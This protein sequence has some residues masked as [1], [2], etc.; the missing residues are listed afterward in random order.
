MNKVFK[1]KAQG[2]YPPITQSP[3]ITIQHER[4]LRELI[5]QQVVQIL[6][7]HSSLM[8]FLLKELRALYI[9]K[10]F[11]VSMKVTNLF[12]HEIMKGLK[13]WLQPINFRLLKV[14]ALAFEMYYVKH[15]RFQCMQPELIT[16]RPSVEHIIHFYGDMRFKF[17]TFEY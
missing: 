10:Y 4:I 17:H 8:Y 16:S 15:L 7:H 13:S 9:C 12:S 2:C 6:F 11:T 3:E 1:N 5:R 14:Q